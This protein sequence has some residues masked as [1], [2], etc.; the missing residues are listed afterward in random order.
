MSEL[1]ASLRTS[2]N[3]GA[4]AIIEVEGPLDTAWEDPDLVLPETGA[5]RTASIPGIDEALLARLSD[6]RVQIMP[7]GGVRIVQR[8]LDRLKAHGVRILTQDRRWRDGIDRVTAAVAEALPAAGTREAVDLLLRQPSRWRG[9]GEAWTDQ[10]EQRSAR[11]NRL[12]TPPRVMVLGP[13][14]IGK[15]T[16]LNALAGRSR[17]VVAPHPGT[18]RDWVSTPLQLGPLIVHWMDAPG[19]NPDPEP[20]E[21]QAIDAALMRSSHVDLLVAAADP[22][23]GWISLPREPDL[24]L[25]LRCDLGEVTGAD[26]TC[27][28]AHGVGIEGV[29][30]AVS[31]ALVSDDDLNSPRPWRFPTL[32]SPIDE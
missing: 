4:V 8:L 9:F 28:A 18:T 16:L 27:A 17:A 12:L 2:P 6:Y 14:N 13:P 23:S 22:T 7:H 10:D 19:L 29:V 11:L 1:T 30:R 3:P 21:R 32:Q 26:V 20:L 25:G 15:S 31:A 24:R 5:L